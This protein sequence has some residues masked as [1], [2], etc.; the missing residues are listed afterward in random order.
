[1]KL[2]QTLNVKDEKL[3]VRENICR[4]VAKTTLFC[5]EPLLLLLSLFL[6]PHVHRRGKMVGV[7][8]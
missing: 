5:Q 7:T 6:W 2:S 1:M 3:S 4:A 8:R